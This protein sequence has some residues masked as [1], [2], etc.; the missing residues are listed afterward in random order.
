MRYYLGYNTD[1]ERYGILCDDL[2]AYDGL[3]CGACL[4]VRVYNEELQEYEWVEDRIEFN[5][6]CKEWY[7]VNTGLKG[8][9][10]AYLL[11]R[12]PGYVTELV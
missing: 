3:H 12:M 4:E 1:T 8:Q 5:W 2:W 11:I 10:L 7:L 6:D 9:E